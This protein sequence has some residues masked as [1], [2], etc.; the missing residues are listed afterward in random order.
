MTYVINKEGRPLMPT[1]NGGKVRHLLKQKKA[2]IVKR[3]PFTIQLLYETTNYTQEVVLGIDTGSQHIGLSAST[4][5]EELFAIEPRPRPRE[6]VKNLSDKS[7]CRRGRRARKTRY[8]KP[9]FLNRTHFKKKGWLPPSIRSVIDCH[10]HWVDVICE[11][12]PIARVNVEVAAF[13][14]Q[15]LKADVEGLSRPEGKDY[16]QGEQSG[17]WNVREY[18]LHR[19]H[20]EC[21]CCHG[22]SGDAV[23]NVH[24]IESRKTGGNASNNLVTLCETCHDAY[25]AGLLPDYEPKRGVKLDDAVKTSIVGARLPGVLRARGLDVTETFGYVTK[26]TRIE[27]GLPKEHVVDALCIAGHPSAK[28]LGEVLVAHKKRCHNRSLHKMNIQAGESERRAS[29][30]AHTVMGFHLFDKVLF[31]GRECFI[32]GK[33]ASGRFHVKSFD[34]SVSVDV[35]YKKLCKV[36]P[37]GG[38]LLE[39]R[40]V[41]E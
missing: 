37:A 19:D 10:L 1:K 11:I 4:E 6:I 28:R 30:C 36:S 32:S 16:Q 34:G 9:R 12:L 18:V 22:E 33:R 21:Q 23:L 8:R 26:S 29:Q 38:W 39:R 35:S 27:A 41:A 5:K 3:E 20:H 31:K 14:M 13:D 2:K 25:H 7:M 40:S 15:K 24:H 17:F